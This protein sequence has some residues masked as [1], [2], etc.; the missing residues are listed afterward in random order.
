MFSW[1]L[2]LCVKLQTIFLETPIWFP[3]PHHFAY[4]AKQWRRDHGGQ[5][6]PWS[7][8][9]FLIFLFTIIILLLYTTIHTWSWIWFPL[10]AFVSF[11]MLGLC[12]FGQKK[13]HYISLFAKLYY[14]LR[15]GPSMFE[16][17]LRPWCKT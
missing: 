17:W 6:W 16:T 9:I 5:W 15:L 8:P 2:Y 12:F 11:C 13:A 1:P 7:P 3:W 10:L 4:H 14:F